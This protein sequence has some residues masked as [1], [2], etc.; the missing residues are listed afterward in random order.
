[1]PFDS[2]GAADGLVTVSLGAN[3]ATTAGE[4]GLDSLAST[5]GYTAFGNRVAGTIT[6]AALL[7]A[8]LGVV[9][10]PNVAFHPRLHV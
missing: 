8:A 10:P 6:N 1:V 2:T 3:N 5:T 7:A 4:Y 9:R